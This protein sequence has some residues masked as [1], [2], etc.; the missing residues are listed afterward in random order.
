MTNLTEIVSIGGKPGLHR[1]VGRRP[2]GIIVE[3]LDDKKKRFP[4]SI[5]EKISILEDISIYTYEG[6]IKLAEVLKVLH[7]K[8]KDGLELISKKN[9]GEEIKAFFR[10]VLPEY[11]ED[12]VYNSD[13]IKL[14]NW[15]QILRDHIDI[16]QLGEEDADQS[17]EDVAEENDQS[18]DKES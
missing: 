13:I 14:V 18:E 5:T 12:Q 1:I 11:D 6:D 16:D 8:V 17:A 3:T 7:Q 10:E 4:G 9:S 2:A 15:Y